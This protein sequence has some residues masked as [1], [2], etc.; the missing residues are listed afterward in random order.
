LALGVLLGV[1]RENNL[2]GE[3]NN[4]KK[5]ILTAVAVVALGV[6]AQATPVT[7]TFLENGGNKSLGTS[8]TF[9]EGGSQLEAWALGSNPGD[10]YAKNHGGDENGLGLTSDPTHDNEITAGTYVQI[11]G[12][13]GFDITSI[14]IGSDTPPDGAAVYWS[15]TAGTGALHLIGDYSADGTVNL[16]AYAGDYITVGA[17]AGNVLLDGAIG[18]QTVPDGGST[19]LLLGSVLTGLGLIKRKLMA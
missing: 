12:L 16:S 17:T 7:F 19:V 18:V 2:N 4:M 8:S 9:T 14:S 13:N 15:S 10:L 3:N 1:R 5:T 11:F 6:A